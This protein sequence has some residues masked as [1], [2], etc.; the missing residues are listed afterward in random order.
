MIIDE[1]NLFELGQSPGARGRAFSQLL[2]ALGKGQ[3]KRRYGTTSRTFRFVFASASNESLL[4]IIGG[5]SSQ[6]VI[7]AVADRLMTLSLTGREHGVFDRLPKGYA[8][9]GDF[10]ADL[11][12]ASTQEHGTAMRHYLQKLVDLSAR[13]PLIFR[14]RLEQHITDFRQEACIEANAGS[15][16]RVADA[17]GLVYAAGR[18]ARWTGALPEGFD[19]LASALEC[20]R[21]HRTSTQPQPS[22]AARVRAL[23]ED[24]EVIDLDRRVPRLTDEKLAATKA[25][26]YTN[27]QNDTEILLPPASVRRL[28][29]D[30]NRV[31]RDDYEVSRML[32]R[33]SG[34]YM[35]K[36]NVRRNKKADRVICLIPGRSGAS[37]VP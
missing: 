25:F 3:E 30:W 24:P 23:L 35:T 8:D 27:P 7:E 32:V 12:N 1:G 28:I 16:R 15:A 22:A 4:E 9:T 31:R 10:I 21:L 20:Y 6:N 14:A 33:E 18:L 34:R 26:R 37:A 11:V 2:M 36:R 17:F 13:D 19:P 5:T 29:P